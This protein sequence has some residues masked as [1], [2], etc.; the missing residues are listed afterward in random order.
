MAFVH[1]K[2][3]GLFADG[4]QE[5]YAAD[6][7]NDLLPNTRGDVAAV[8]QSRQPAGMLLVLFY[9]GIKKIDDRSANKD[10]PCLEK[11]CSAAD[12]DAAND[13]LPCSI[14]NKLNGNEIGIRVRIIFLLCTCRIDLLLKI[15]LT[16]K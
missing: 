1:V 11:H 14:I 13:G 7:E 5:P 3:I 6:A 9:I 4:T 15:S 12:F 8:G 2:H 16:I 10:A